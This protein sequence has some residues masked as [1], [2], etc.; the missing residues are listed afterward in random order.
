[1]DYNGNPGI[2]IDGEE[3][4]AEELRKNY[5]VV[6]DFFIQMKKEIPDLVIENCAS[7]GNR[8]EPSMINV[9]DLASFSD[10]H[11]AVEIPYI[12]ANLHN[13]IR[14]LKRTYLGCCAFR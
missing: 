3:S 5:A 6:R 10:A 12:A 13:L 2:R 14:S 4:D 1:M 11:E 9:S 8:L 7:G